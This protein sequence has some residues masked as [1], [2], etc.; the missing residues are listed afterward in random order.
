MW[1][2]HEKCDKTHGI[3]LHHAKPIVGLKVKVIIYLLKI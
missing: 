3:F 2:P 1:W